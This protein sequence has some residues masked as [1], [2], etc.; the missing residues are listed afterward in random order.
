MNKERPLLIVISSNRNYGWIVPVFLAAN[1]RWADYIIITNQMSTDGSREM[2][3]KYPNVIVVD[4]KDMAFKE[5]TRARMA[6][7]KGREIA[8]GRDAIYFALDIDEILPANWQNTE[9]GKRVLSS[10]PGDMFGLRWANIQ[11]DNSTYLLE[12][13]YMYK[14]FYDNGMDWQVCKSELHAPHLPYS[15]WDIEPTPITDFPNI[16][17]GHYNKK[18]RRY[19]AKYYGVLDVHQKRS[20]SVV[21]INRGYYYPDP[22]KLPS[23]SIN[24]E[25]LEFDFDV[26]EYIDLS[27]KP[28]GLFLIKELIN[29][30]GIDKFRGV[31]IWDEEFCEELGV[32]DPR[33]FVWKILHYYLSETQPYR[34]TFI[35]RCI[36][37][38]LKIITKQK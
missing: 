32:K 15:S 38:F 36:D 31:D 7:E 13:N 26:F 35:I 28:Q 10:R 11:P 18:W 12:P 8:A 2:Y 21:S 37:K 16:H 29:L 14:I 30:D 23:Y 27:V 4:D 9:D 25:W 17:F 22:V 33:T 1:S 19:N 20:K 24:T 5:N 3:T 34:Y 6:F